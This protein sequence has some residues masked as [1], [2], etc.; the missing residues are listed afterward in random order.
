V[1]PAGEQ[2]IG[3]KA[4]MLQHGAGRGKVHADV[5]KYVVAASVS[6]SKPEEIGQVL[7]NRGLLNAMLGVEAIRTAQAKFGKRPLTGEEVRWGIE[8]LKLD[9]SRIAALGIE[10]MI[11]PFQISCADH[12]G[13]SLSRVQQWDGKTWKVVSEWIQADESLLA[14]M[15]KAA[16][17]KY[18]ADKSIPTF[19]C[20]KAQ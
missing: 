10:G 3:Y 19:D 15:V 9:E 6:R 2:G 1:A 13:A 16:A 14:P 18:R 8:N 4:V 12:Q 11:R 5:E 17:Q 7:Y 20:T